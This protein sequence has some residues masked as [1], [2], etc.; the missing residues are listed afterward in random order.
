MNVKIISDRD[1]TE[2]PQAS[3]PQQTPGTAFLSEKRRELLGDEARTAEAKRVAEWLKIQITM[4]ARETQIKTSPTKKLLVAAA[5]LV[6]RNRID[7]FRKQVTEAR[8]QR[9]D[10]HFL[11]S[12]PWAPYS[13]ANMDLEFKTHFG[14]S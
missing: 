12:G 5:H 11:V 13:F 7:E 14:V 1:P 4:V 10:L 6:E 8:E 2:E 3:G 9:R